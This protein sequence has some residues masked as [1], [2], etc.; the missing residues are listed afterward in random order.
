MTALTVGLRP[1]DTAVPDARVLD[2]SVLDPALFRARSAT[3]TALPS[4]RWID[5]GVLLGELMAVLALSLL[6]PDL[7]RTIL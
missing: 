5:V 7:G 2:P 3:G 1:V 4:P 6:L